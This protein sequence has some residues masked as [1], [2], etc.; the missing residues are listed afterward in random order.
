MCVTISDTPLCQREARQP[1]MPKSLFSIRKG[2]VLLPTPKGTLHRWIRRKDRMTKPVGRKKWGV[3]RVVCFKEISIYKTYLQGRHECHPPVCF[4]FCFF[5]HFP[6][7]SPAA[8][9]VSWLK[10]LRPHRLIHQSL[11]TLPLGTITHFR[12]LCVF[13]RPIA[14]SL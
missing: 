7:L 10:M 14:W 8:V 1:W 3:V 2:W 6:P 11:V 5:F 12:H 13:Y 9:L 4:C